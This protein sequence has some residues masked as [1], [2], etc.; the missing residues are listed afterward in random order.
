M[1]LASLCEGKKGNG[2]ERTVR[3]GFT[4]APGVESAMHAFICAARRAP[5]GGYIFWLYPPCRAR[6]M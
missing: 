4:A 2:K 1:R 6:T 3:A 5:L